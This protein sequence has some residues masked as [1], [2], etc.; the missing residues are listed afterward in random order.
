MTG[1]QTCA[2]PISIDGKVELVEM[3]IPEEEVKKRLDA[4]VSLSRRRV[5]GIESSFKGEL[6]RVYRNTDEVKPTGNVTFSKSRVSRE[7][8]SDE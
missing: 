4:Q 5:R 7:S 1:V 8:E 2:L 6:S 3:W